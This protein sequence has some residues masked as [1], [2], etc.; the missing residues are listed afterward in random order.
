MKVALVT[1]ASAGIG[2]ATALALHEAG[3]TVYGA[4]RRVERMAGLAER[5]I[6]ILEMDVTDDASMVA[7]VERI[8]EE[9][10]RIDVLVN[11]AG[12]GSYGAFEDVPLAEGKYQFEVNL[13][14]L[15]RLVQLTTPHMRA[16]GSGRIVNISSIGGKIYEPLGGWYHSTKFAV[17]GL[18]DSL[19]LELKPFGIDVVVVEPGAIR[20][21]WG[22]IAIENL[23]KTSGDTA[24]APQAKAL[25]KFF[26]Q[27]ARASHPKVIADVIL[28]AVR[29]RRPKIRYAAGFGAKPILFVRRVLPDRAFDALFLGA[30]RRFT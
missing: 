4:A 23:M 9:S 7:G 25:A 10:G 1:G 12:Y 27:T 5:G 20:T 28:K 8:I 17:E 21:E 18:S 2:E 6:K 26:D 15:A 13:F 29:A 3:Y 14:G 30:L 22:G 24:Y 11:N 16:Q 19:R